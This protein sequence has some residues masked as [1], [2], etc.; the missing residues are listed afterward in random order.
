MNVKLK[1]EKEEKEEKNNL[2]LPE[3]DK[4]KKYSLIIEL[5]ETLVH[6]YEE[7]NNYVF[8]PIC[9]YHKIYIIFSIF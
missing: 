4:T 5:D 6:Y 8:P 3:M 9:F 1:E 7:G 2:I